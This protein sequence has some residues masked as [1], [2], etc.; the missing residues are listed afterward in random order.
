MILMFVVPMLGCDKPLVG[1]IGKPL[2]AGGLEITVSDYDVRYLEINAGD[3]TYEYPRP[4]LSIPI[5]LKNVGEGSFIYSPSH[6]SPQMTESA[7]P[8][9]YLDPG[10][11]ADLPPETKNLIP[12]VVL[13]KGSVEGQLNSAT[14]LAKGESAN[15]I[16]LF[17]VPD[18]AQ[19]LVLSIPPAM[20]RGK[21]PVLFRIDYKP[22]QPKG[23]KVYNVGDAQVFDGV[24]FTVT[25]TSFEYVKTNDSA[26]G[27]GFSSDP[28]FKVSYEVTNDSDATIKLDPGH[29]AVGIRGAALYGSDSAYNRVKFAA[30]TRVE[31][32]ID[33]SASIDPGKS[34]KDFVLFEAPPKEVTQLSFEYPAALFERTGLARFNVPFE[35]KDVPRPK[36]LEPK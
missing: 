5:T 2:T 14:T 35:W 28:L 29:K 21:M 12:G 33:G 13:D 25:G 15:D 24:K 22:V 9:L 30:T 34:V 7:T 4:V 6:N 11:D 18:G 16:L 10:A 1:A 20:N 27:E 19:K 23:P 3:N 31:G 26:Q 36:E 17:E 32:Q 8:L